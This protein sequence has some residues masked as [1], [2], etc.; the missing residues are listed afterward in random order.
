MGDAMNN[1]IG[2]KYMP[3]LALG[4]MMALVATTNGCSAAAAI[5]GATQGCGGLDTTQQAQ[6]TVKAF[7][8]SVT[9]LS[10]SATNVEAEWLKVCNEMNADLGLDTTQTTASAACGVLKTYIKADLAKGV[11]ISVSV[12]NDCHADLSAQANCEAACEPPSCVVAANCM[13]GDIE[14]ACNGTCS[15]QCDVTAPSV[16]CMGTCQGECTASAAVQCTGECT[17]TCTAPTWTGS[18][19]AGCTAMFSGSCGGNCTG[20]CNGTSMNGGMCKGT[21]QGTC[22]ANASGSCQAA[23]TGMFSGG[24]CSGMCTGKCNVAAGAM[25]SGTCNGTCSY[26]PG[27]AT[28]MGECH[29]TCSAQ[30]SPPTCSGTLTCNGS[31]ECHADCQAKVSANLVCPPPQLQVTVTGDPALYASYLAHSSDIGT[32]MNQTAALAPEIASAAGK[33]QAA[34]G[35]ATQVGAAGVACIGATIS[36]AQSLS[37]SFQVSAQ[38]SL[39]V[40]AM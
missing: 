6:A 22:D 28:C 32:A 11:T 7:A 16:T 23:C 35:D 21:C 15:G 1:R 38:A 9:A 2:L 33:A 5:Q 26:M 10:T 37:G 27:S 30:V 39:T 20:M 14:V 25:C 24:T 40:S 34:F 8:D 13:G 12:T 29:G 18:C 17:G 3:G 36:S 4:G 31:S 19:D